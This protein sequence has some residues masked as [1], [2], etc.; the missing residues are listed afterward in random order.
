MMDIEEATLAIKA[1]KSVSPSTPV[2]ATMTFDLTP[3]GFF[4]IMG[5]DIEQAAAGL[6]DAG[7][8]IVGS[9]CGNGIEN[10]IKIAEEFKKHTSLPV[11]IQSNAGIP[12]MK[13]DNPL[14]P[15]TPAFMAGGCERLLDIGVAVIGGCCGTTPDHIAAFRKVIDDHK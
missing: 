9:N 3:K 12:V 8:D 14:Y 6:A 4:T 11:M 5:V 13:D 1:A 15:E 2:A 7:A 10:M